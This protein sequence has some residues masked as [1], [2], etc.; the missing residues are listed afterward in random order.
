MTY[1][2]TYSDEHK[3]DLLVFR[4]KAKTDGLSLSLRTIPFT[5]L[6]DMMP[7]QSPRKQ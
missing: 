4:K 7:C 6:K 1:A 2:T 3:S 5:I